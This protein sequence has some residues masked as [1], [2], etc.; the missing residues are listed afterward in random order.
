MSRKNKTKVIISLLLCITLLI[1]YSVPT[2]AA[3]EKEVIVG[4]ELFGIKMQTQGIPI[5]GL[6]KVA[7]ENGEKAPAYECGL[8]LKDVITEINGCPATSAEQITDAVLKSNGKCISLK[9]IRGEKTL[10]ITITPTK[11]VDG[12]YKAGMWIRD[13][14]AGI[15][16]V[17]YIDPITNEFGGLGHGICDGDTTA[18]L[19]LGRGITTEV[20]L[21]SI[22]KGK[23]GHPGEIKGAFKGEKT[24]ALVKNTPRG[25]FGIFTSP[26][27][28]AEK[29]KIAD[30]K[31]VR[32]GEA[33]IRSA[34]SGQIKDYTVRIEKV[35]QNNSSCK[36][37]T[38]KVT[39][40]DLLAITGGIVQGMSG[41]PIIQN[42]KLVGA[43]TH[44]TVND[45]TK[46]YG[47]FIENMLNAAQMPM[48]KA[49]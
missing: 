1:P 47:I 26:P 23:T 45:P 36:N 42:G 48:A 4:G 22:T 34:V 3:N 49:S 14:A 8:K 44:V 13:S 31:D 12:K 35:S 43:V 16:T 6:E 33:K 30:F 24:G 27:L 2:S 37:L 5:V 32:E 7:T 10:N 40:K 25:V 19:P 39:D 28:N 41:S 46:G 9:I 20:E 17:T 18:L 29:I 21:V 38:I 15:G 11:G